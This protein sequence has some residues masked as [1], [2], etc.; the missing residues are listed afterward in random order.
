[1]NKLHDELILEG[2]TLIFGSWTMPVKTV[3][4]KGSNWEHRGELIF[5]D[6]ATIDGDLK[7]TGPL[8]FDG[9]LYI[10]GSITCESSIFCRGKVYGNG[11]VNCPR[12]FTLDEDAEVKVKNK[13][14]L[15]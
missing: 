4:P 9:D 3:L 15:K 1:M 5:S 2:I 12:L 6:D 7:V 10:K 13:A 8:A 11:K 14:L